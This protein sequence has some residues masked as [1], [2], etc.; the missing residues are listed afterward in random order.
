MNR[1]NLKEDERKVREWQWFEKISFDFKGR[2]KDA[3]M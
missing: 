1:K 3:N 2:G